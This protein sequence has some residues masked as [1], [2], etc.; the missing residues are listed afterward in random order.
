MKKEI[1]FLFVFVAIFIIAFL[2][3]IFP[4]ATW[5]LP[6]F[7]PIGAMAI[8][9]WLFMEGIT[10]VCRGRT[11]HI[12]YNHG[13][14]SIR[15]KD[16][17]KI[18]YHSVASSDDGKKTVSLG[19]IIF[20][21]TGGFDFWGFTMP[22]GKSDPILIYPSINHGREENNYHC[23]ANLT[24]YSFKELPKHVKRALA[25]YPHRVDVNKTP[26]FYGMT[27]HFIGNATTENLKIEERE[28]ALNKELTE[29]DNLIERLYDQ[30]RKQKE[31]EE[32]QYI[33][34]KQIKAIDG[35]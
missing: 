23:H 17:A 31:S 25:L 13:H 14:K 32:K 12:L 21:F 29:K 7:V 15:E 24:K 16:I 30:L 34:G 1:R 26:F 33:I 19:D 35:E 22:G 18:P 8:S 27:S 11:E 9:F 4:Q 6:A 20:S 10:E 2:S 28:R 5:T 3:I